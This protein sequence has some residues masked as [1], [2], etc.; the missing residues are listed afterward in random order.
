MQTSMSNGVSALLSFQTALDVESN[1]AGNTKSTGFKA[2]T[3]SFS[4]MFYYKNQVGLGVSA[5]T[6]RK[7]F[8]QGQLV[9]S[10]S[11]YDFAI[12]GEGFFTVRHPDQENTT[13]Y[14]RA[15]QF[16]SDK[17]NNLVDP[18]DMLVMGVKP[19]VTGDIITADHTQSV[20]NM[21][22]ETEESTISI[23][24]YMSD[25]EKSTYETGAI[26]VSGQNYKT[27]G[28][29]NSDIEELLYAYNSALK[30]YS[31]NPQEG[32]T[33]AKYQSSITFPL[34]SNSTDA[35]TLEVVINGVKFQQ[36]FDESIE[37]TL[38]Q[39]S[40]KI[41]EMSGVT[42]SVD[43]ATGELIIE[44]MIPGKNMVVTQAKYNDSVLLVD[45]QVEQ[46][47]SG[48]NLI[49]AIYTEIQSLV[50]RINTALEAKN[51]AKPA[52]EQLSSDEIEE[53]KV[54]IATNQSEIAN[55]ES[56][57]PINFEPIVLDL[58]E[59][60]MNS[61]LYEKIVDGDI[62]TVAAYPGITSEDGKLY[63]TDG[64]AKFLVGML[65][66]VTFT[67]KTI[68]DPQGDNLYMNSDSDVA[69]YYIKDAATVYGNYTEQSNVDL[70]KELVDI[71]TYQKAFEAN[72]KSIT[73][74]DELVKTALDLKT[75]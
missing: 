10:N 36:N 41:N 29:N 47:G 46:S 13:Y 22:I 26:G 69:A 4:D 32:E 49:D 34:P 23:N 43:T 19:V 70:S 35:Y 48:R 61:T 64:D 54:K 17:N 55:L 30:S 45:E 52:D 38:N 42:S 5:D 1:N 39:F 56:G 9:P 60:G 37:N 62:S 59:L 21:I 73:T 14:T 28:A 67:D 27:V 51:A 7:D 18:N 25:Y 20:A 53:L 50:E 74:S 11:E 3:V 33:A 16:R 71:L 58:N 15:G 68:L 12:D 6:P 44:S 24:T 66:P 63:L 2:D 57:D 8:S 31:I 75:R 72:S 65:V 40:N